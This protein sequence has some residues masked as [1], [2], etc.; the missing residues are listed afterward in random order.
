MVGADALLEVHPVGEQT[1][2]RLMCSHHGRSN[3]LTLR[4]TRLPQWPEVKMI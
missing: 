3:L 4:S 2:L 1:G